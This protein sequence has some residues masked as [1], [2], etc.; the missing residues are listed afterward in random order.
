MDDITR[1]CGSISLNTKE[2]QTVSLAPNVVNNSRILAARLF[3]KHRVNVEALVRTLKSMWHSIQNFEVRDL[4]SS[5]VLIIFD[6]NATP[7]KILTQG[8]CF[9]DKYLIR[10]Y[11][12]KDD[13]SADDVSFFHTTF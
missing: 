6:D 1:K 2:A 3:T 13:E 7:M 8:P 4:G 5:T 10:L 11:K 12:P 9:F